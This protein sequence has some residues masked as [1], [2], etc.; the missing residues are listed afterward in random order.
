M[1]WFE[2]VKQWNAQKGGKYVNPKKGTAEY[3]AVKAIMDKHKVVKEKKPR[4]PRKTPVPAKSSRSVAAAVA[5]ASPF[6]MAAVNPPT[7][8][9][10][11]PR[12]VAAPVQMQIPVNTQEVL[13]RLQRTR[14]RNAKRNEAVA[15]V[16]QISKKIQEN[17]RYYNQKIDELKDVYV[18][19]HP[20]PLALD[21]LEEWRDD[22]KIWMWSKVAALSPPASLQ[23][24]PE[25]TYTNVMEFVPFERMQLNIDSLPQEVRDNIED[26]AIP[27]KYYEAMNDEYLEEFFSEEGGGNF[28]PPPIVGGVDSLYNPSDLEIY[29]IGNPARRYYVLTDV[30]VLPNGDYL[31]W[32]EEND[33]NVEDINQYFEDLEIEECGKEIS[34]GDPDY[35]ASWEDDFSEWVSSEYA[36]YI[37]PYGEFL[38]QLAD[39][40]DATAADYRSF[41]QWMLENHPERPVDDFVE[42]DEKYSFDPEKERLIYTQYA[43][44]FFGCRKNQLPIRG[45]DKQFMDY[46]IERKMGQQPPIAGEMPVA[47]QAVY[48]AEAAGNL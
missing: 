11:A 29:K 26:M 24:L 15:A 27:Q 9:E 42:Y 32:R 16:E 30:E 43:I 22:L 3:N 41:S 36:E 13:R 6:G 45:A 4:K 38:E 31:E 20:R 21:E 44:R 1:K 34:K 46:Y 35:D 19:T 12:A 37:R 2:A 8:S 10:L 47:A 48:N 18:A 7:P 33:L 14:M 5:S 17:P 23:D 28:G 25:S 40:D 39:N